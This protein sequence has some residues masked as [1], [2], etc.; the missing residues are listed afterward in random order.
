MSNVTFDPKVGFKIDISPNPSDSPRIDLVYQQFRGNQ[1]GVGILSSE[2]ADEPMPPILPPDRSVMTIELY[3]IFVPGHFSPANAGG[4]RITALSHNVKVTGVDGGPLPI[5]AP[6]P[7]SMVHAFG[8]TSDWHRTAPPTPGAAQHNALLLGAI[9]VAL[10]CAAYWV[11][12]RR[13][14]PRRAATSVPL[15][16]RSL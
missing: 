12:R 14:L 8:G 15:A 2:P 11:D 3:T 1:I 7:N 9:F 5:S 6:A 16:S 10:A 13:R 4:V